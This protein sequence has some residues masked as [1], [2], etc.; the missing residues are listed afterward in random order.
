MT[1][2]QNRRRWATEEQKKARAIN[3]A[4]RDAEDRQKAEAAEFQNMYYG[5]WL[6]RSLRGEQ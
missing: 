1:N 3:A 6:A 2:Y 4:R 5:N